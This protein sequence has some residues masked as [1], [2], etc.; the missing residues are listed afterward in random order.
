M[1]KAK[2]QNIS[3][4]PSGKLNYCSQWSSEICVP[5]WPYQCKGMYLS[6]CLVSWQGVTDHSFRWCQPGPVPA[7]SVGIGTDAELLPFEV[8]T[9]GEIQIVTAQ[10]WSFVTKGLSGFR[11]CKFSGDNWVTPWLSQTKAWCRMCLIFKCKYNLCVQLCNSSSYL[12]TSKRSSFILTA[13]E[14]HD[15]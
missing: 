12:L 10:Q 1:Q 8:C 4:R 15:F 13:P 5:L 11:S 7:C 2:E 14:A 3:A 6:S 9:D